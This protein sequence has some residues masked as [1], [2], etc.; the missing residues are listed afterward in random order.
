MV[1]RVTKIKIHYNSYI[2]ET[3][4]V[5]NNQI[6]EKGELWD[7]VQKQ[8]FIQWVQYFPK[9]LVELDAYKI[10]L[11][12]CGLEED[13]K[14]FEKVI[15]EAGLKNVNLRFKKGIYYKDFV[16]NIAAEFAYL[17]SYL[18]IDDPN[19]IELIEA[20]KKISRPYFRIEVV[21]T[22]SS[23]KSTLIN[24]LLEKK[25]LPSQNEACTASVIEILDTDEKN[26]TAKVFDSDGK[27]IDKY[28]TTLDTFKDI[29]AYIVAR[30]NYTEDVDKILIEGDIPF[31]DA[32]GTALMLVDTP[33]T[34]NAQD[35]KHQEIT[36]K[37]ICKDDRSIILYVLNATQL[38]T[39]DDE[40][41][42]KYVAN[43]IKKNGAAIEERIL[44]V[45]N[46][47]DS[48][49]PEEEDIQEC[50]N[51]AKQYLINNGIP[52]PTMFVCSAITALQVQTVLKRIDVPNLSK[53]EIKKLPIDVRCSI[54]II[55]KIIDHEDMHFEKYATVSKSIRR[56]TEQVLL[57]AIQENDYQKQAFIHSGVYSLEK[58]ISLYIKAQTTK[59]LL[60]FLKDTLDKS[61]L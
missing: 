48:F 28:Q 60:E 38:G 52:N 25:L 26:Y 50:V 45:I 21:S 2:K 1:R 42:L 33:G 44:F 4:I 37:E 61:I 32:R 9:Y 41:L 49:D 24:A 51:S 58:Y 20:Y 3:I 39:T 19:N 36:F 30:L 17:R 57:K 47:M 29:D 5:I 10:S 11:Q 55:D 8:P 53:K 31:I 27:I 43:Q 23:G 12:F 56:D 16:E 59:D 46:K 22:M 40:K 18:M 34:N 13:W 54:P 7:K 35:F 14:V 15:N 6:I